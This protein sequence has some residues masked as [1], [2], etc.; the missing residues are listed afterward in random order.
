MFKVQ[1]HIKECQHEVKTNIFNEAFS[2]ITEY[3]FKLPH[4]HIHN[5]HELHDSFPPGDVH[6]RNLTLTEHEILKFFE[7]HDLHDHHQHISFPNL[8]APTTHLTPT[9]SLG[10]V[11]HLEPS[12]DLVHTEPIL[13]TKFNYIDPTPQFTTL[14]NVPKPHV[15]PWNPFLDRL[16]K[17]TDSLHLRRP[18]IITPAASSAAPVLIP[19][20]KRNP[21]A[22]FNIHTGEPIK[23]ASR[24]RRDVL[25]YLHPTTATFKDRR[26]AGVRFSFHLDK[27]YFCF[28][29]AQ[30]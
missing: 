4:E 12:I 17:N 26:I 1:K 24:Q 30:N 27:Y 7:E 3:S 8:L 22:Y 21:Y 19:S 20:P 13:T 28:S 9:T 2:L 18:T 10:G 29:F 23:R 11:G 6:T 15:H 25:E 16:Y 14:H 5:V